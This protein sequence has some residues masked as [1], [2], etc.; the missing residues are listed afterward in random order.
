MRT[1]FAFLLSI[2]ISI[3]AISQTVGTIDLDFDQVQE[4]Y[5]LFSPLNSFETYLINN[6]G[7][8]VNQWVSTHTPGNEVFLDE[9]GRLWRAGKANV[10]DGIGAGGRGGVIEVFDWN[11]GLIWSM[12][13][14]NSLECMHHDFKRLENGNLLILVWDLYTAEEAIEAGANP[15]LLNLDLGVWSEYLEEININLEVPGQFSTVWQWHAWDHLVQDFDDSK[16]NFGDITSPN[17]INLNFNQEVHPDWLHA[18]AIDY[19]E[20][21]DQIILSIPHFDE[22]WIIDHDL[23]ST[24]ASG[25]A[26]DLLFRWGNP[27][28]YGEGTEADQQMFFMHNPHWVKSGLNYENQIIV[29]NNENVEDNVPTSSVDVINPS[30][31]ADG[32]YDLAE[33]NFLPENPE[34]RYFLSEDLASHRVSSAQVLP[35]GNTLICSGVNATLIEINQDEEIVWEY[36]SPVDVNNEGIEQGSDPDQVQFR[37]LWRGYKYTPDFEGFVG[38]DLT[39]TGYIETNSEDSFCEIVSVSES[40]LENNINIFPNPAKDWLNILYNSDIVALEIT[41]I[42]GTTV[43]SEQPESQKISVSGLQPGTYV[44]KLTHKD[45]STAQVRFIKE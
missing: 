14:C 23:S 30:I 3:S 28:S 5:T 31:L 11:G 39:P 36:I 6:C 4:G 12:T 35:N 25:D 32:T 38:K 10:S 15:D 16:P 17:K 13:R 21:L 42:L 29:F 20:D 1:L 44:L 33:D 9:E 43:F 40:E 24:E 18:N 26:G 8:I 2:I 37:W 7:E 45:G 22:F 41:S 27:A 34:Y 19:N